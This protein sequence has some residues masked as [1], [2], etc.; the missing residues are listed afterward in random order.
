MTMADIPLVVDWMVSV[1]LWQRY[2]V[3]KRSARTRFEQGIEQGDMLL[4]ADCGAENPAVGFVWC[5][6]QGAFGLSAYIRLIGVRPGHTTQGIGAALLEYTE[7]QAT[8]YAKD[9]FLLVSD[10]N[11][12]AQRFYQRH[13]YIQVGAIPGYVLPDVTELIFRKR[14]V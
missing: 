9:M 4:V 3:D 10:F 13:G 8:E 1:P 5:L 12:D 6:L 7:R 14:L 2:Q 11:V